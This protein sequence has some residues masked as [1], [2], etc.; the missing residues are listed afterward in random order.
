MQFAERKV[1]TGYQY[2]CYDLFGHLILRYK[3]RLDKDVLDLCVSSILNAGK[4]GG[5]MEG[6]LKWRDNSIIEYELHA[7]S[8]WQENEEYDTDESW[9]G[10]PTSTKETEKEYTAISRFKTKIC[11]WF[12]RFVAAFRAGIRSYQQGEE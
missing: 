9:S 11:A 3:V 5:H 10:T 4:L 12:R 6:E 7:V 1:E 8:Q 2:D